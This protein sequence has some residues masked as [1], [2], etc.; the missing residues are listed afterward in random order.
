VKFPD[1]NV[2]MYVSNR[3]KTLRLQH[4]QLP[5]MAVSSRPTD[6]ACIANHRTDQML[7]KQQNVSPGQATSLIKEGAKRV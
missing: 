3:A 4:L 6:G 2:L 5:G 1:T 7:I